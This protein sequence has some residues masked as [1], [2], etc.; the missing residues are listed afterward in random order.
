MV[1][2]RWF[3]IPAR[4][5]ALGAALV[6]L[7]P[8]ALALAFQAAAIPGW[9]DPLDPSRDSQ[10]RAEGKTLAI[11]LPSAPRPFTAELPASQNQIAPTVLRDVEGNFSAQVKVAGSAAHAGLLVWQDE[12]NFV[13]LARSKAPNSDK[14]ALTFDYWKDGQKQSP[15]AQAVNAKLDGDATTLR[16]TRRMDKLRAEVSTDGETWTD[17]GTLFIRLP[18]RMRLGVIATGNGGTATFEDFQQKA[19]SLY[20]PS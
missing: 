20:P 17:A 15:P 1:R 2:A 12:R 16:L 4:R 13:I 8:A 18:S 3:S 11:T 19:I 6:W 5:L 10:I 14:L 7:L 9:G